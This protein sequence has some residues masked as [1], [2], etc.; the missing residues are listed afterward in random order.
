MK[1]KVFYCAMALVAAISLAAAV[2]LSPAR[3]TS[4]QVEHDIL[5][6]VTAV[7]FGQPNEYSQV[8]TINVDTG[9]LVIVRDNPGDP[10]YSD[11]A[12]TGSTLVIPGGAAPT[13]KAW[14]YAVGRS[15][16]G[17]TVR[18]PDGTVWPNYNDFDFLDPKTGEVLKEFRDELDRHG[19]GHRAASLYGREDPSTG[20]QVVLFV[21]GPGVGIEYGYAEGPHLF[22]WIFNVT[23]TVEFFVR[24]EGPVAL[25]KGEN[26]PPGYTLNNPGDLVGRAVIQQDG[27]RQQALN[28][29]FWS[30]QGGWLATMYTI[31]Y[32]GVAQDKAQYRSFIGLEDIAGWSEGWSEVRHG[33]IAPPDEYYATTL[34]DRKLYRINIDEGG[35]KV[36]WDFSHIREL[37][38]PIVGLSLDPLSKELPSGLPRYHGVPPP[39]ETPGATPTPTPAPKETPTPTPEEGDGLCFIATAA[40]GPEDAAV[41]TLRDFRDRYL[42]TNPIGQGLVSAYYKLSP[43]LSEFI[44]EHP[45]LKPMVRAALLPTVVLSNMA[46]H[47]TAAQKLAMLGGAVLVSLALALQMRMVLARSCL[48]QVFR[49]KK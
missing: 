11:I 25:A 21:E 8:I 23:E 9:E 27:S 1:V 31:G 32:S 44:A 36:E 43:P 38:G 47:I 7:N 41:Q 22:A 42:V 33:Q 48:P 39:A 17:E 40:Y 45:V 34:H 35:Y 12:M 2:V 6:G 10:L 29:D 37:K 18:A 46:L 26:P 5:W 16:K 4:S 28:A 13:G 14:L 19:I 24:D 30:P 15:S 20:W 49:R 3:P